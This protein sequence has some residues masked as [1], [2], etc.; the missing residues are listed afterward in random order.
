MITSGLVDTVEASKGSGQY[1]HVGAEKASS[2]RTSNGLVGGVALD[3][4]GHSFE[5]PPLSRL[6]GS[7]RVDCGQ[8]AG[9]L[10]RNTCTAAKSKSKS[11]SKTG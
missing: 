11:K 4:S 5:C 1:E 3:E 6:C 8:L 10:K 9:R 7:T 2:N